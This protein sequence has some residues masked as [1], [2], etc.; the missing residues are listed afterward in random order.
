MAKYFIDCEFIE[1]FHK[2]LFG[3]RRHYI[4]LISVAIVCEDGREYYAVSN[5]FDLEH[6]WNKFEW[7]ESPYVSLSTG[8]GTMEKE[9]W[10][11]DN[12]LKPIHED[13]Y[14]QLNYYVKTYHSALCGFDIK[15]MKNLLGWFGKSNKQIAAEIVDF[16]N[17]KVEVEGHV[18]WI[19]K[20]N[21]IADGCDKHGWAQPQ[22]YGYFCGYDWPLLCSLFGRMIDLPK[23]FPMLCYD[24]KQEI[25]RVAMKYQRGGT[26]QQNMEYDEE[27]A[28]LG[29][30]YTIAFNNRFDDMVNLIKSHKQYPVQTNNHNALDDARWNKKLYEFINLWL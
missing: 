17:P 18:G 27:C 22:F 24:L 20:N 30:R 3:K 2:P 19:R 4:D 1:D 11:R 6:V 26:P 15:G 10:L 5:D 14:Q 28:K 25:D 16:V 23:G 8:R 21:P 29:G 12:V 9:Y 7:K 13:L